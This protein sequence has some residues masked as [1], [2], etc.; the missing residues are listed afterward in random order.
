MTNFKISPSANSISF[1][2]SSNGMSVDIRDINNFYRE[3]Y[4]V[5]QASNQ[6]ILSNAGDVIAISDKDKVNNTIKLYTTETK[7]VNN[8]IT[9]Q[10]PSNAIDCIW[11]DSNSDSVIFGNGNPEQGIAYVYDGSSTTSFINPDLDTNDGFA[12]V[13]SMVGTQIIVGAP[14]SKKVHVFNSV[15]NL[16]R[17]QLITETYVQNSGKF[18]QTITGYGDVM[19]IS[20]PHYSENNHVKGRV[21]IYRKSGTW[22]SEQI[23]DNPIKN[24][25]F[26]SVLCYDGDVL[27]V[28]MLNKIYIYAHDGLIWKLIKT[29]HNNDKSANVICMD[30]K[31]GKMAVMWEFSERNKY[32]SAI[33][34]IKKISIYN[35]RSQNH[36]DHLCDIRNNKGAFTNNVR[37]KNDS[38]YITSAS[39]NVLLHYN[40]NSLS[41]MDISRYMGIDTL[42]LRNISKGPEYWL[43]IKNATNCDVA[44]LIPPSSNTFKNI[45]CFKKNYSITYSHINEEQETETRIKYP[46]LSLG[47]TENNSNGKFEMSQL[48]HNSKMPVIKYDYDT[49]TYTKLNSDLYSQNK[50]YHL[51]GIENN[52]SQFEMVNYIGTSTD[53][54]NPVQKSHSLGQVPSMILIKNT[55]LS[56]TSGWI[57]WH[58]NLPLGTVCDFT[59]ALPFK[60]QNNTTYLKPTATHF[61][62]YGNKRENLFGYDYS[63]ALFVDGSS[64]KSGTYVGNDSSVTITCS[65]TPYLMM[66][67]NITTTSDWVFYYIDPSNENMSCKAYPSSGYSNTNEAKFYINDV[68]ITSSSISSNKKGDT[69]VY[70]IFKGGD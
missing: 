33:E 31:D 3:I 18:G 9:I 23:I 63:A 21:H 44:L 30:L 48:G 36:W 50:V 69:Y 46:S 24:G 7:R 15:S 27:C 49:N 67:K 12:S 39:P 56:D 16:T 28:G 54:L 64:F 38:I 41:P 35:K 20:E 2:P 53:P 11:F 29:I 43:E 37:I 17:D 4:E 32:N 1:S 40:I 51:V 59:T 58:K 26:G 8:T 6:M 14:N 47:E 55:T 19:V 5:P 52:N 66:V 57:I 22:S 68:T 70:A 45:Q 10:S 65:F 61:N 25:A 13:I 60:E 34:K 42:L 62:I